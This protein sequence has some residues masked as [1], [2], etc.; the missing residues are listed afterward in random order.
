MKKRAL[1]ILTASL[2]FVTGVL[3]SGFSGKRPPE[4]SVRDK[5]FNSG[6][7]FI[8]DSIPGAENPEF[9][10]SRWLTVDLPHDYSIMHL[11]GEAGPDKIGPFSRKS[12]GNGKFYRPCNRRRGM[13]QKKLCH[14]QER[15]GQNSNPQIRRSVYGVR[16]LGE[17]QEGRCP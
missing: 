15:Q 8:R 4:V 10:D 2:L 1:Y 14:R 12:P 7:K 13:V 6:W 11:P 5:N 9:N 16:S 17:R 3:L